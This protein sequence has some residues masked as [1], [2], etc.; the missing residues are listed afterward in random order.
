MQKNITNYCQKKLYFWPVWCAI[1]PPKV[2]IF[3]GNQTLSYV[4]LINANLIL[5]DIGTHSAE[6]APLQRDLG[7]PLPIYCWCRGENLLSAYQM[8]DTQIQQTTHCGFQMLS[9]SLLP[10]FFIASRFSYW[11][12][13]DCVIPI[14]PYRQDI[15][16]FNPLIPTVKRISV[17][18]FIPTPTTR[19]EN[20]Y[21]FGTFRI[22]QL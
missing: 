12:R 20:H 6:C 3:Y 7:V 2:E 13:I 14:I 4:H 16:N 15:G 5:L 21:D 17:I 19:S 22:R 8:H 18:Y 11:I 10:V 9:L 1:P